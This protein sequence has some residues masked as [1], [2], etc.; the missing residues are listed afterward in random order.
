MS[1]ESFILRMSLD[2][3][4][5][6]F[7]M[8][9]CAVLELKRFVTQAPPLYI[10]DEE[11]A[12]HHPNWVEQIQ[13]GCT[14]GEHPT[15]ILPGGESIKTL[16]SLE[17]VYRWLGKHNLP[18][19]GTLVAVGGGTL[20]DLAGLAA[21][22]WRRG[23]NFVSIPTT[24]LAMVD[25][26]IG[27]KTAVNTAGVKNTV[28][29]F[30]PASGILADIG[31]LSTLPRE[32]WQGGMAE[33]IKT[34]I[35]GDRDLFQSLY[36][37]RPG[38][39]HLLDDPET[40]QPIGGILGAMPWRQWIGRAAAVKADIVSRDF[41]EGDLRKQLNLGHTLGHVLEAWSLDTDTPLNHGQ[42]V[43]IGMA[44]VFR[45]AA[46]R[47]LCSLVEAIQVVDLLESCGL[48]TQFEGL[49]EAELKRLLL[50]DKKQE[51]GTGLSWVLPRRIG[52]VETGGQITTDEI[53]KWI[54]L[55]A[56]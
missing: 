39:R 9:P 28:G 2:G 4:A 38:L 50:G 43:A 55:E 22:T 36:S 52:R 56:T 32:H 54:N 40:D 35:I 45:I 3:R 13:E 49:P 44:V 18:R 42:A 24:L 30:H 17:S 37:A 8:G 41:R 11:V 48:P 33:L 26:A 15:L 19:D 16:A 23:V 46:E 51:T 14:E 6:Q 7:V 25:A 21:S 53:H 1:E 20:L 12:V 47:G 29:T 34:A 10:I 27:G 31:F 5:S